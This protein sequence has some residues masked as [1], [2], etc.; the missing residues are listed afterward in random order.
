MSNNEAE[1]KVNPNFQPLSP[2]STPFQSFNNLNSFNMEH[3]LLD[4]TIAP[5][6]KKNEA[7][8]D[9]YT[10]VP[11]TIGELY[12]SIIYTSQ[13]DDNY[14]TIMKNQFKLLFKVCYPDT[15]FEKVYNSEYY[16]IL[17]ID[18]ATKELV[19]FAVIDLKGTGNTA[20]ILAL[21]VVKEYQNKQHGSRL[22]QKCAEE[23]SNVGKHYVTLIVQQSNLPAIKLYKKTGFI[24]QKELKDYYN[25]EDK[26]E[27]KAYSMR[28]CLLM[29]RF[30]VF[31]ILQRIAGKILC[32]S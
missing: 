20:D 2:S 24:I 7:T 14:F 28:K 13:L 16:T 22:I 1:V 32:E 3:L 10:P 9:D 11:E 31:E 27:R 25:F 8:P 29:Q 23:L 30:W 19:C 15:F 4:Q 5:D 18:K 26:N 12:S 6:R 21:G 17:G